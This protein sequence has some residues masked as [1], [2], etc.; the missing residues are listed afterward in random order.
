MSSP[1]TGASALSR[2]KARRAWR[3]LGLL[4][5]L[6]GGALVVNGYRREIFGTDAVRI[7]V[8][9]V[10]LI[11][12]WATAR[13]A[14]LALSPWLARRGVST[15]GP[16]GFVIRLVTIAA[17]VVVALRIVG[18][19]PSTLEAGGA[20][21]A[22]ILGLAAQQTIGN[23][24]AGVVLLSARPFRVGERVKLQGGPV[25]GNAIEGVVVDTGLL[26]TTLSQG[27]D[28]ILIPNSNVLGAAVVPLREPSGVDVRARLQPE[29]KPTELQARLDEN[30]RT[31]V[32]GSPDIHLEEIA[33][34]GE[35]VLRVT[36]TPAHDADGAKLADEVLSAL[37]D[38]ASED[39]G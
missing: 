32:R 14:G 12:G 17:A 24:F 27:D 20:V 16:F 21:T 3:Q 9:I 23:V 30:I 8:A 15:A 22:I 13:A 26:Y 25:G 6:I 29:I 31:P 11:L 2:H 10:L 19:K 5:V 1:I 18:L 36:A 34:G 39:G 38:A 35:V 4:A 7:G 28:R 37:R 33:A